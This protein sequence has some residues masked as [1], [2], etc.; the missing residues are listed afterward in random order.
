MKDFFY[1][2]YDAAT[3]PFCNLSELDAEESERVLQDIRLQQRGFASKRA[4]DYLEI[5]RNLELKARE[6]FILKGGRPVRSFPHYMTLGECPWLLDWYPNG[7]KLRIAMKEF[8]PDSVSF[9]YGDLFPTMRYQDGKPYRGQIYTLDEIYNVINEFGLPQ[10]WNSEGINGPER[11]IEVQ[12]WDALPLS[13]M[14]IM[15]ELE[16]G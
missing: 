16:E 3:G 4:D 2:Y 6:L 12:I 13:K 15:N 1:H 5:R 14:E 10:A 7:R 11:Y 9:T 8:E